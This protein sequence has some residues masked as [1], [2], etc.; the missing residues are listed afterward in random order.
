MDKSKILELTIQTL[1]AVE[2]HGEDNLA[3][4][5]GAIRALKTLHAAMTQP[6][7]PTKEE[8]EEVTDG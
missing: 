1:N 2:V 6:P 5:L 4:Q 3:A 8:A 7:E